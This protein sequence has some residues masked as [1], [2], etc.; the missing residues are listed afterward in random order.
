MAVPPLVGNGRD[1]K[2]RFAAGN[3]GGPGNPF[4]RR[5]AALRKA[6]LEVVGEEDIKEVV[7][8]LLRRAKEGDVAAIKVMLAYAIGK[9]AEAVDP[10][11]VDAGE[12]EGFRKTV[13]G[14]GEVEA[15]CAGF[16]TALACLVAREL[17]PAVTQA[18]AGELA[19]AIGERQR[20]HEARR[21]PSV[22]GCNGAVAVR[23]EGGIAPAGDGTR[24]RK[25]AAQRDA[26]KRGTRDGTSS[27][28][29]ADK[30]DG[31]GD[32]GDGKVGSR[33]GAGERGRGGVVRR[34]AVSNQGKRGQLRVDAATGKPLTHAQTEQEMGRHAEQLE[35]N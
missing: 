26:V 28:M 14:P 35:P 6:F 29:R 31:D 19:Q 16:P 17:V 12:W 8:A 21:A 33:M 32:V 2:G 15:V 11:E 20:L 30:R 13:V 1:A 7:Q 4:A 9:P 3:P 5:V 25:R 22:N 34:G 23:A 27:Q 24:S 18:R 10:D